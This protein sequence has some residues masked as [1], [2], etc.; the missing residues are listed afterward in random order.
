MRSTNI[1]IVIAVLAALLP[2][3]EASA[4]L[5]QARSI[6]SREGDVG[7]ALEIYA[8]VAGDEKVDAETRSLADLERALLVRRLG[9]D[10]EARGLLERAAAGE[11][12]AALRAR[13]ILAGGVSRQEEEAQLG[14]RVHRAIGK[15]F[16]A[17]TA[18]EGQKE[19]HLLG[20]AAVPILAETMREQK[21]DIAFVGRGV[22]AMMAIGG[23]RVSKWFATTAKDP[24]VI[25]RRTVL[26]AMQTMSRTLSGNNL[27]KLGLGDDLRALM[28]DPDLEVATRASSIIAVLKLE[29]DPLL[30]IDLLGRSDPVHAAGLVED[31][32]VMNIVKRSIGQTEL[33]SALLDALFT[34]LGSADEEL[35]KLVSARIIAGT[36]AGR[37]AEWDFWAHFVVGAPRHCRDFAWFPFP[38]RSQSSESL[39]IEHA[40]ELLGALDA[41]EIASAR[42]KSP[43]PRNSR[44]AVVIQSIALLLE[45]ISD[46]ELKSRGALDLIE[47]A[48]P[49]GALG[50]IENVVR[51][52]SPPDVLP[53]AIALVDRFSD[54]NAVIEALS[55]NRGQVSSI[56]VTPLVAAIA[57]QARSADYEDFLRG[58]IAMWIGMLVPSANADGMTA[59][60]GLLDVDARFIFPL[61]SAF[62]RPGA[63][64]ELNVLRRLIRIEGE[65]EVTAVVR[66]ALFQRL[67]R[68]GEPG[69][70]EILVAVVH[71]P[72]HLKA[73]FGT[74]KGDRDY[75]VWGAKDVGIAALDDIGLQDRWGEDGILRLVTAS[76]ERAPERTW[77]VLKSWCQVSGT[78]QL[79]YLPTEVR[80]LIESRL[81]E[82]PAE[83]RSTILQG[84]LT[85]GPV[86]EPMKILEA[87]IAKGD[88]DYSARLLR[89]V[90]A[91]N[92]EKA[93]TL[94]RRAY[95]KEGMESLRTT[96]LEVIARG[97]HQG[98]LDLVRSALAAEEPRMRADALRAM[99]T[100]LGEKAIPEIV[101]L[102]EDV[103]AD[104]RHAF[105]K[106]VSLIPD[107]R[108]VP[109]L[110]ER[111]KDDVQ[112]VREE[113]DRALRQIQFYFDQKERWDKW[114]AGT[115]LEGKSAAEA[116]LEQ[117]SPGQS[118]AKRLVAIA[119]LGTL[120]VPETLPILITW[121]SDEDAEIAAAAAA[122]VE[123]INAR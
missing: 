62:S 29:I 105:C 78:G 18:G 5:A 4:R 32:Q 65:D 85:Y 64:V 111:L 75:Q 47:L 120:G 23:P 72:M 2:A 38:V 50:G 95:E 61:A 59:L 48:G 11:G 90:P 49:S 121:M 108:V 96:A 74:A 101:P 26:D 12:S 17:S 73:T 15:L 86:I 24:D 46:L 42:T 119:S 54:P 104:V 44:A 71:R 98:S 21:G 107:R 94:L 45:T 58:K 67:L 8:A 35:F 99:L 63:E 123:R 14:L 76:L 103:S 60:M 84:I 79:P 28:A 116:L 1:I 92:D 30:F 9:R 39:P 102:A 16:S 13:G 115:G 89:Y 55:R 51:H 34:I 7:R 19:L 109:A 83:V 113:A 77:Y 80:R 81:P 112:S 66:N 40:M 68:I 6:E 118:K 22:T 33:E 69:D 122:A 70:L 91:E 57:E 37:R 52:G 106:G 114:L 20:D 27:A 117:A 41:D 100:I 97:R 10:D 88:V 36:Q 82:A 53:R 3:Q 31:M 87:M 43:S 56:D 93:W 25:Y 110:I